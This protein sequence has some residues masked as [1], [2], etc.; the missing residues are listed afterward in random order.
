M[1]REFVPR[2]GRSKNPHTRVEIF[3]VEDVDGQYVEV[4]A[5]DFEAAVKAAFE[6]TPLRFPMYLTASNDG[7]R[8]T[9]HSRSNIEITFGGH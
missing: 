6:K 8:A 9:A 5:K 2:S 1:L 4:K 7:A 3:D